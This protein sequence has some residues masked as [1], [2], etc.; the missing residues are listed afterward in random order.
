MRCVTSVL[1]F[2]LLITSLL[3]SGCGGLETPPPPT[4]TRVPSP[5]PTLESVTQPTAPPTPASALPPTETPP[6]LPTDTPTPAPTPTA[7]PAPTDTETPTAPQAVVREGPLNVRTGPGTGYGRVGQLEEGAEIEITGRNEDTTWWQIAYEAADEGRAW[8]SVDYIET[9]SDVVVDA[10]EAP[11]VPPTPVPAFTGKLVLQEQSGG[12]I[13]IINANGTGLRQLTHGLDPALSPDGSQVAFTRWEAPAGLYLVNVD[14]SQERLLAEVEQAKSP[15]WSL[16]GTKVAFSHRSGG[17]FD[18][19]WDSEKEVLLKQEDR[20]WKIAVA[21]VAAGGFVDIQSEDH[22]FSPSWSNDGWWLVYDGEKGLML[23]DA[24]GESTRWQQVSYQVRD[25]SPDW[26]PEPKGNPWGAPIAHMVF[27]N[28]HWEIHTI[29]PDGQGRTRLTASPMFEAPQNSVAPEWSPDGRWL[30][31][32]TDRRGSW[33]VWVMRGDGSQQQPLF[34]PSVLEG[35]QFRYEA[36]SEQV[37]D[38]GP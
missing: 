5:T 12:R 14:G 30:A 37:L 8:V 7:S 20:Y 4:V 32:L 19:Y 10:I 2:A 16:D 24:T 26:S 18:F 13:F 17:S 6:P 27:H 23:T 22:S 3:S 31:F 28:D 36:Q 11:P 35:I 25:M 38:W 34:G 29:L 21:D 1:L 15:E 33:E 9:S